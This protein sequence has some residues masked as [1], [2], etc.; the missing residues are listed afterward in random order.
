VDSNFRR[1]RGP[2]QGDCL[3][4]GLFSPPP[5]IA[6]WDFFFFRRVP[7]LITSETPFL[8]FSRR[9]LADLRWRGV[10]VFEICFVFWLRSARSVHSCLTRSVVVKISA[11]VLKSPCFLLQCSAS[12]FFLALLRCHSDWPV[13]SNIESSLRAT[14]MVYYKSVPFLRRLHVALAARGVTFPI[15]STR[16][17]SAL[18]PRRNGPSPAAT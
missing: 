15:A 16:T 14:R 9:L 8:F 11:W 13:A 10:L 17:T 3:G 12:R 4:I 2:T 6:P 18:P 5:L 7:F 1:G